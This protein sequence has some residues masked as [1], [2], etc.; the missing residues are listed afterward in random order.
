MSYLPATRNDDALKRFLMASLALHLIVASVAALR[1][2]LSRPT[3]GWGGE[4][5][6]ITIGVV[7]NVPAI[8]LPHSEVETPNRVVDESKGLYKAEPKPVPQPRCHPDSKI[9]TQQAPQIHQQALEA[10]GESYAATAQRDPVWRGRRADGSGN[11]FCH[12]PWRG[13][14]RGQLQRA[15]RRFR[16]ALFV[17]RRRG[18]SAG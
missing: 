4:Q 9:R 3:E 18:N 14:G 11:V 13:E 2:Y 10:F 15:G 1:L 8:P 7:G 17:V 12:G 6:A 5:G 16:H